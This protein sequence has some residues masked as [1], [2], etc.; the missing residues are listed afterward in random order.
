M[1]PYFMNEFMLSIFLFSFTN[2]FTLQIMN[3]FSVLN[4]SERDIVPVALL[5]NGHHHIF[6]QTLHR[7]AFALCS[8]LN[9]SLLRL[10]P[11]KNKDLKPPTFLTPRSNTLLERRAQFL[12]TAA[13]YGCIISDLVESLNRSRISH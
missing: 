6:D 3:P 13:P 12:M 1:Q 9:E 8:V 5:Q 7:A 2:S 4:P 11:A 10:T